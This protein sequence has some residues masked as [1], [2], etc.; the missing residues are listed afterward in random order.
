[1]IFNELVGETAETLMKLG[2]FEMVGRAGNGDRLRAT[3]W[4]MRSG[5]LI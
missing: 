4:E 5:V 3:V 2:Y 1:M